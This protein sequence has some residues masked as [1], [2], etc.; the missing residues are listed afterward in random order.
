MLLLLLYGMGLCSWE[1]TRK[2]SLQYLQYI[3]C[4][5]DPGSVEEQLDTGDLEFIM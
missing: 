4:E 3:L 1:E 2:N 5:T